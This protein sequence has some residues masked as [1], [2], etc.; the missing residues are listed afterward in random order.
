MAVLKSRTAFLGGIGSAGTGGVGPG[1]AEAFIRKGW[2][3]FA[4]YTADAAS[5]I[6]P[7]ADRYGD[8]FAAVRYDPAS[9]EETAAAAAFVTQRI[10]A[11]DLL[12]FCGDRSPVGRTPTI[13]EGQDYE[14][15]RSIYDENALG[16]LRTVRWF[17]PILA[18]G[19]MKRLCF[20][21]DA[22]ALVNGSSVVSGFARNMSK[23]AANMAAAILFNRLRPEGYTFRTFCNDA[24]APFAAVAAY[25]YFT[26]GRS[27]EAEN[28]RHSDENR[29]TARD[30]WGRERPW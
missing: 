12:A 23:A 25:D 16:L 3:V 5:D 8:S 27:L 6:A 29:F 24:S 26:R 28:P 7:L 2:R 1:I 13:A 11:V 14:E 4:G 30:G 17:L 10:E 15:L 9:D 19:S 21:T 22:E 18:A 20:V